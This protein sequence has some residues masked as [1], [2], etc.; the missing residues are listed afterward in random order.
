MRAIHSIDLP[1]HILEQDYVQSLFLQE[2]YSKEDSLVFKGGTYMKH[3]FG[4]DRFSEDLD[5][6][7]VKDCDILKSL[8]DASDRIGSFGILS[9]I[10]KVEDGPTSFNAALKYRGPLYNGSENSEGKIKIDISKRDDVFKGPE[11]TRLFFKYPESAVVNV[12]GMKKSE[13][14]AEK[15]RA[16][17]MRSKGRDLYD[18]WFLL[19]QNEEPDHD[20]FK[21]KMSVME[22]EPILYIRIT[23]REY[24]DDLGVLLIRP[25]PYRSV[26]ERVSSILKSKGFDQ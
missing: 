8:K 12:L 7:I 24:N 18:V 5:F 21:K 22:R 6:T 3:A 19:S 25:P 17:C 23:E 16:L 1:L 26:M 20:L 14:L 10:E 2:L 9:R 15:I 13:V 11:W 4:L